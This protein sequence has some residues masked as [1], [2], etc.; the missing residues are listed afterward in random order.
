MLAVFGP[1]FESISFTSNRSLSTVVNDLLGGAELSTPRKRPDFVVLPDSS[2]G[3][4]SCDA[5]DEKHEICGLSSV[6]IVELKRGGFEI[7]SD[8]KDQA[9]KYAREI[10]KSGK[11]SKDTK[12]TC[13]VLGASIAT[14]A[15]EI[16]S[17][18]NTVI[19]PRRYNTILGQAHARTFNLLKKVET[20]KNV[21]LAD[22][23]LFEIIYPEQEDLIEVAAQ[24]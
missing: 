13:Y 7:S 24:S 8:E 15:Q 11:V 2:I 5:Y 12:I 23:D 19:I 14:L 20:S 4:Y 1:E 9:M 21:K 10:R 22:D 17:E 6:V 3:I 18:G 16:F